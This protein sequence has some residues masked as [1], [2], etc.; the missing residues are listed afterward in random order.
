MCF[1]LAHTGVAANGFSSSELWVFPWAQSYALSSSH[2]Q[3]IVLIVFFNI[4]VTPVLFKS[5]V[6]SQIKFN[7][8]VNVVI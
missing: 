1:T 7:G 2:G 5:V 4:Q 6:F 8:V 3:Q